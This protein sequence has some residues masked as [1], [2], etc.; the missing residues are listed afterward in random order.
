MAG[1]QTTGVPEE[2]L[3]HTET[4]HPRL[5]Y[6]MSDSIFMQEMVM[7]GK[8]KEAKKAEEERAAIE[9]FRAAALQVLCEDKDL[10]GVGEYDTVDMLCSAL[11]A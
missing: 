5:G 11:N 10:G 8:D 2:L 4:V 1:S 9:G 6:D 3:Q 7:A